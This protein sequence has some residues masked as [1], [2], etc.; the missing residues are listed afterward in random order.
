MHRQTVI[1][2]P[3][4]KKTSKPTKPTVGLHP[5]SWRAPLEPVDCR[6]KNYR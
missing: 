2:H 1:Q 4:R 6:R 3:L 5:R